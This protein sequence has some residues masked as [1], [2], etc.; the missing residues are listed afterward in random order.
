M[1]FWDDNPFSQ[2]AKEL[3]GQGDSVFSQSLNPF[4][5]VRQALSKLGLNN[6]ATLSALDKSDAA[7]AQSQGWATRSLHSNAE[8]VGGYVSGA[9]TTRQQEWEKKV[10]EEAQAAQDKIF[11]DNLQK[12]QTKDLSASRA[13]ASTVAPGASKTSGGTY[14]DPTNSDHTDFLGL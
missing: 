8:N 9:N 10:K 1:S 12:L 11:N 13:S 3:S 6:S 14:Y 5:T 2:A 7:W 4:K